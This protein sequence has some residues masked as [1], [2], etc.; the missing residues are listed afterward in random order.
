MGIPLESHNAIT[1][2]MDNEATQGH[3]GVAMGQSISNGVET[4]LRLRLI[5]AIEAILLERESLWACRE[6]YRH[7]GQHAYFLPPDHSLDHAV[8]MI[9]LRHGDTADDTIIAKYARGLAMIEAIREMIMARSH[10]PVE[11]ILLV[12]DALR[13]GDWTAVSVI[14]NGTFPA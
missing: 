3:S 14:F 5:G 10:P 12:K 8:R 6:Y 1:D 7:V 4:R 9:W 13:G 2:T 11:D